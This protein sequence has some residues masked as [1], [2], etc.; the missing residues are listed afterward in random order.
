MYHA[1]GTFDAPKSPG[2]APGKENIMRLEQLSHLIEITRLHSISKAAETLHISQPALSASVKSLETELG[3]ALFKRTN[4]GIFLT[5]EG[6]KI[7]DDAVGILNIINGWY[8]QYHEQEPEGEIHLACTPIISCYIT[9]NIIVPFQKLY[10]KITIFVHSAQLYDIVGKLTTTSADIA[11]TTLAGGFR[12]IEQIRDM[13]WTEQHLFT[14]E[15]RMFIGAQHP[16]AS[17]EEL[18]REDLKTLNLAYYSDVRDQ[19]S[20]FYEP[21]FGTTYRLA[22]KE[23]ILDLVIKNEAVFIQPCHLFRHDYRVMEKLL[24]EKRIP[25]TEVDSRADVFALHAPELSSI[26]QLFWDY[27][28][29]NFSCKL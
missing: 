25:L 12:F 1:L 28:I 6:E 29:E 14:D 10:P 7:H 26:E 8:T 22:N 11:L 4:R 9:P 24:V 16:L 5:A 23:D 19:I 13:N 3:V 17:K 20:R 15:R 27:I 21:F 2:P 18:T